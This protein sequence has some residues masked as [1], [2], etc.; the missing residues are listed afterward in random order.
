MNLKHFLSVAGLVCCSMLSTAAS[1]PVEELAAQ[2][3]KRIRPVV[4]PGRTF[5]IR[6]YGAVRGGQTDCL[7]AIRAA[8]DACTQSG[9]G[10]VLV[11][12]GLYFVKGPVVLKSHVELHLAEGAE[13]RFSS[14]EKDYLPAVPTRWEGTEVFNYSPL[15]YAY[16]VNNIGVTGKGVVNGQ[17]TKNFATWKP[18]QKSDQRALRRMGTD[19]RPLSERLFGE[20]HRLR[21]ALLEPVGCSDVLIEGITLVDAPFW[22]IH[23]VSCENVT[24]RGVTVYS[25]NQN[26]DGCD[27][28]SSVNVLIEDCNFT[29]G[30]DGIAIKSGRDNDAWRIGQPT[31][32]VLVRNC[33]FR[34]R[35]NGVCIG[36][37]ISG[38]VRNVCVMDCDIPLSRN[39]IYFKSNLDRGGYVEN[40][41]VKGI[42][43]DTLG[44]AL[45][46]FESDYKSESR[47]NYP[48]RFR[49]FL[50][51]EMTCGVAG[52]CGI[53]IGG[54]AALPIRE[55]TVRDV[56]LGR[57]PEPLRINHAEEVELSGVTMNGRPVVY[58]TRP[59]RCISLDGRW[60][61]AISD[62]EPAVFGSE[63]PVPGVITQA[64]P[65]LGEDLDAN[66]TDTVGYDYVWYLREFE[67]RGA[68]NYPRAVLKLRAKYNAKVFLNGK[69]IG[70]DL[71]TTYSHGTFDVS[72][73]LVRNGKN[74]LVVRVGSW[75][76][77]TS[78]S[79]ENSAEWWRNSR[80]PGIWDDVTLELGQNVS[81]KHM[82]IL[83]D[84]K[85]SSTECVVTV[86]NR[87]RGSQTVKV[88][89]AVMD[90][91]REVSR[92]ETSLEVPAVGDGQAVL[93]VPSGMLRPWS[94]GKEGTPKLYRMTVAVT[95]SDG[96]LL[97]RKSDDFG[98]RSIEVAGRD[99]LLNGKKILFRAEN[100]AF[101]RALNRWADAV[102][103]EAWIR[104]FLRAAVQEYNFNY[105]RIHLGH[106]YGKWYDIADQEGIMLQDEWRYM[107]DDEPVGKDREDAV[108]EFTRW[109]EQNV[110]H[111]SIVTWDQENE[112]NVKLEELK[113]ALR[114]YDPTRLWGEDDFEARHIYE[115]TENIVKSP[116][117]A[118]SGTKPSTVL[119]SCR[120][121]T[122]EYGLLEPRENFK[123]SRTAS[124]WGLFN[125]TREDV[126]RLLAD[127]HADL[128]TFYRSRRI[129]AWA[130]F[131][132]LS[133]AVN[134]HN[135]YKGNIVDSLS[136]QP[137]L[138]V[139]KKLNEPVGTSVEMLQARE[140]YKDKT[141][142]APGRRYA[143]K[144]WVWNDRNEPVEVELTVGLANEAG[145]T[146]SVR[147]QRLTVP[148]SGAVA[149][150][151]S[152]T[153]PREE[154]VYRIEPSLTL[155]DSVRIGGPGR[156]L[157][158]ARRLTSRIE[159]YMAFGGRRKPVEG[160]R[161]LMEHFI[162]REV[163][164]QV[165][166]RIEEAL[167]GGLLD[168]MDYSD[169]PAR[170][171][172]VQSTYYYDRTR[173]DI[174]TLVFDK[175]G[176]VVSSTKAE[177]MPYV[178]LPAPIKKTIVEVIGKV[179]VD[180]SKI[181]RRRAGA[182]SLYEISMIG[183][184]LK[185][186]LTISDSG[187]LKDKKVSRKKSR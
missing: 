127:L 21:P 1:G 6:E 52:Q 67:V 17:G 56:T 11:P 98:Y 3:E 59:D 118:I 155:P 126:A 51:E 78:P 116:E 168:K 46:R 115:Y 63:V 24:V 167:Q 10:R 74:R 57:T 80:A 158:V 143:K 18:G 180:E 29:T 33:T 122:N 4:F 106:A 162:G 175:D 137:N 129:Q 13:L 100:V 165:Q 37:E 102:F 112:G 123:T 119:E 92:A 136:P 150:E 82:K 12:E 65:S 181:T 26:S 132:L 94:P 49:G 76:T 31:E 47:E 27:P 117:H 7:P 69:E 68:E 30:D 164:L 45:I 163:P 138:L 38:G 66:G 90:G 75:N 32:N 179:P 23:P 85:S 147:R 58:N 149:R 61:V 151:L 125:Y 133:G 22:V 44:E 130:P 166:Y 109:V 14:D 99:V 153:M 79:K 8:I 2:I 25:L 114:R 152:F 40:V 187:E 81:V 73:A 89:A 34:S 121:W 96:R 71:H 139:L 36:S 93:K 62:G 134:G 70:E 124:G 141:L 48:T 84:L 146:L 156:R 72:D 113:A 140:W 178:S 55:V 91:D 35:T 161:S 39:G 120:L 170:M 20:G 185:Y 157:M 28:E 148:A 5:D 53:E 110:N 154:G 87:E 41:R 97:S 104:A 135:F 42:R 16:H 186:K 183:S 176:T 54:F 131:A 103:D 60:N 128:G 160:S 64:V 108:T 144:V 177:A 145:E 169:D 159:E 86:D 88:L 172:T 107:H 77:A 111:P 174:T 43:A 105:L 173:Q 15:I 171:Y 182:D 184:D 83:P 19:L 101:V 9:G 50:F 95:A 142:Y